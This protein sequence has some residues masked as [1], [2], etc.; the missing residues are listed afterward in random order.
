MGHLKD[1]V[2]VLIDSPILKT[3]RDPN[4]QRF[5]GCLVFENALSITVDFK[6]FSA[7]MN[8]SKVVQFLHMLIQ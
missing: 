1:G 7:G 6:K 3:H 5:H 8:P 4:L 2:L